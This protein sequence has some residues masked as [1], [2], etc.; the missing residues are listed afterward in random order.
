[1][2]DRVP[3]AKAG[4]GV[5]A[6][7]HGPSPREPAWQ[8]QLM[9]ARLVP[10]TAADDYLAARGLPADIAH[11]A[12]ARYAPA[13]FGRPA[14]VFPLRAP[15]RHIVAV[16]GRYLDRKQ[17]RMRTAGTKQAGVLTTTGEFATTAVALTEAPIDALSLARLGMPAIALCGTSWPGWLPVLL[18]GRHVHLAFNDDDAGDS[19]ADEMG[20]VL[21]SI[22]VQWQR[23]RPEGCKDWNQA[24]LAG[25]AIRP[26]FPSLLASET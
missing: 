7:G 20:R 10:G 3:I 16:Q 22:A 18:F 12:G 19:M 21:T 14:V 1:M 23:L 2:S 15:D 25:K 26:N 24:L 5:S 11:I 8:Q 13:F 6:P 4:K 17:P 9:G